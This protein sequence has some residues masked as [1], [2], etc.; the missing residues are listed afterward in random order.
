[1]VESFVKG[2]KGGFNIISIEVPGLELVLNGVECSV[3]KLNHRI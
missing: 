2:V 1:M 3:K